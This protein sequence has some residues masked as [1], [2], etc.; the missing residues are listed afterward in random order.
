MLGGGGERA[1]AS[2]SNIPVGI[3]VF[4]I[5][6]RRQRCEFQTIKTGLNCWQEDPSIL[7]NSKSGRSRNT[8]AEKGKRQRLSWRISEKKLGFFVILKG[9][10]CR[11]RLGP[12][13]E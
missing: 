11:G 10:K 3:V 9:T 7:V 4:S 5:I 1:V 6:S 2:L 12:K 13:Y 8:G